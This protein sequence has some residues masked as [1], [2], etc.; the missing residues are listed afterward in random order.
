LEK[1]ITYSIKIEPFQ[2]YPQLLDPQLA[3]FMQQLTSAFLQYLSKVSSDDV[4]V[5]SGDF[6][7]QNEGGNTVNLLTAISKLIYTLAKIRGQKVITRFLPNEPRYL[8]T[9]MSIFEDDSLWQST[10]KD[11]STLDSAMSLDSEDGSR[12]TAPVLEWEV[13][14]VGLIWVSH[15]LLTPFDLVTISN[16]RIKTSSQSAVVLPPEELGPLTERLLHI[17]LRF[18]GSPGKDREGAAAVLLRLMVRKDTRSMLLQWFLDWACQL[19]ASFSSEDHPNDLAVGSTNIYLINGVLIAL[20]GVLSSSERTSL[21]QEYIYVVY[22]KVVIETIKYD[23]SPMMANSQIRKLM[24]KIQRNIA[25]LLLPSKVTVDTEVPENVESIIDTLLNSLGDRDTLV[26]YAASKALS[27]ICLR[28]PEEDGKQVLEALYDMYEVNVYYPHRGS[29]ISDVKIKYTKDLSQVSATLWHGLTLTLAT[30]LTSKMADTS[31]LPRVIQCITTALSFEQ[32]KA[33]HAVG[34][35]VRDAACYAAWSLARNYS[36][37]VLLEVEMQP[38]FSSTQSVP[39]LLAEELVKTA[40]LDSSGNIRRAASAALQELIGRHPD[41]VH[42][43]IALV[44]AVDYSSVARRSKATTTVCNAASVLG[45]GDYWNGL[46]D[47]ILDG[48]RGIA[49]QDSEG[50]KFAAIGLGG[51]MRNIGSS[52]AAEL[53][54]WRTVVRISKRLRT[55]AG[56][57]VELRHGVWYALA[58]VVDG[59]SS[60]EVSTT[61]E[62][63]MRQHIDE[64]DRVFQNTETLSKVQKDAV[65]KLKSVFNEIKPRDFVDLVSRRELTCEAA[66]RFIMSMC[67]AH[68]KQQSPESNSP[69]KFANLDPHLL[70]TYFAIL[71]VSLE[72]PDEGV[73]FMALS[74][75]RPFFL[76]LPDTQQLSIVKS[77]LR[78]LQGKGK[79]DAIVKALGIVFYDLGDRNE[80]SNVVQMEVL[81]GILKATQSKHVD[82]RV[83]AFTAISDGVFKTGREYIYSF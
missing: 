61:L 60:P 40:C 6:A 70:R 41:T 8:E 3:N 67:L 1:C 31:M 45:T 53:K 58:E 11:L 43:G 78:R 33:T 12:A 5:V 56:A 69:F 71:D 19:V 32:R 29:S 15:L 52:D 83:A 77:W 37:K 62:S 63:A 51:L 35:N 28:L 79:S 24:C 68:I 42:D 30:L 18:I 20:A 4:V 57:D 38:P 13:K 47:G 49:A 80:E 73:L 25:T 81:D 44:Q 10:A 39:Q 14:Y 17:G 22:E 82:T 9:V 59:I 27:A 74:A 55:E 66:C 50:R 48:G 46:V 72:C 36:T 75:V 2:E 54:K 34:S 76:V 65:S 21:S 23:T 16:E 7:K 26:R 64:D